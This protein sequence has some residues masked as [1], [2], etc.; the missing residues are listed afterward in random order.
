MR[1][2]PRL[3]VS[4]RV[5][6]RATPRRL[7]LEPSDDVASRHRERKRTPTADWTALPPLVSRVCL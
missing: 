4:S 2:S 6:G 7:Q 5:G 1:Y 3:N